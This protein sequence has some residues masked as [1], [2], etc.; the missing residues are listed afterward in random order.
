MK[1]LK[2]INYFGTQESF[3]PWASA[4]YKSNQII[5]LFCK[6]GRVQLSKVK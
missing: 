3:I 5:P 4:S 6:E 1:Q 2:V